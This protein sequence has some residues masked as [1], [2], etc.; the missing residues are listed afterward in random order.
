MLVRLHSAPQAAFSPSLPSP[1]ASTYPRP[2]PRAFYPLA[3]SPPTF[4]F[5]MHVPATVVLLLVAVTAITTTRAHPHPDPRPTTALNAALLTPAFIAMCN[6]GRTL[7]CKC[8][9]GKLFPSGSTVC[10]AADKLA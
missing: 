2:C 10:A 6:T 9:N 7:P 8:G 4:Y 1:P 5:V 3:P